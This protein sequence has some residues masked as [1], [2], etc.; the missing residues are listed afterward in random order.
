VLAVAAAPA[1]MANPDRAFRT[2]LAHGSAAERKAVSAGALSGGLA[3][4]LHAAGGRSG[5]WVLDAK[6]GQVLFASGSARKLQ[7]ASNTKLF[8]TAT[9]L[10]RFGPDQRLKTTVWAGDDASDGVVGNGLFLRGEGDPT[11]SSGGLDK[12]AARVAAA[13]VQSVGGPLFYDDAYLDR[14]DGVPQNGIRPD[15]L[16]TLSALTLNG[17]AGRAP[18]RTAAKRLADALRRAGVSIGRKIARRTVPEGTAGVEQV[19]LLSSPPLSDLARLTNV[20]SD[21]FL[22]EMLLK[23]VAAAFGDRGSTSE[24]VGVVSRFASER[25]ASFRGENGSGLSRA[26]RASPASV[27]ALLRSM[28]SDES[29]EDSKLREAFIQSL[30]VAGRSG[31]LADR[32][33]GTAA[34]GRCVAKTGTLTGVS[35]LSGY[36]FRSDGEA[37]VFSILNNRVNTDA[38][39]RAQDRMAALI[40]RYEP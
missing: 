34:Q 21:N 2:P 31:T 17:G 3:R 16:G 24:G 29:T 38:A 13:G 32:M 14:L 40:A 35:A 4:L 20:P 33:R 6:S 19:A 10:G 30:A 1:A 36:C 7:L 5:A 12:L 18:E 15:P 27:G 8:T 28:L 22:A 9:A 39:R 11:L 37:T 23:D 26:D 25:G